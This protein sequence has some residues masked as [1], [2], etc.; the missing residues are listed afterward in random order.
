MNMEI[1]HRFENVTG[2]INL[3]ELEIISVASKKNATVSLCIKANMNIP[4]AKIKLYSRDKFV[5][6]EACFESAEV[7]GKEIERRWQLQAE[8]DKH[9]WIPVSERLPKD[10]YDIFAYGYDGYGYKIVINTSYNL[11]FKKF[12]ILSEV[13]HWKPIIL[14]TTD[15]KDK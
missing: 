4:F 9:R 2:N 8:L 6:A 7:I 13:T 5:D 12:R 15:G 3:D 10:E 14:P 1:K 11:E